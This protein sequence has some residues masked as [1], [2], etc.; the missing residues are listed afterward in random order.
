MN[1]IYLFSSNSSIPHKK[2]NLKTVPLIVQLLHKHPTILCVNLSCLIQPSNVLTT[3]HIEISERLHS[4]ICNTSFSS[5]KTESNS[6]AFDNV[7]DMQTL[8]LPNP[9]VEIW[10]IKGFHSH[11]PFDID[12][13]LMMK[14]LE[15]YHAS[16]ASNSKIQAA[17]GLTPIVTNVMWEN[18]STANDDIDSTDR[19]TSDERS[20]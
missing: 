18:R 8:D 10:L 4:N 11:I 2:L 20:M 1:D 6:I 12:N 15:D 5:S 16:A 9:T 19:I 13:N 14:N 7:K 17:V 3:K